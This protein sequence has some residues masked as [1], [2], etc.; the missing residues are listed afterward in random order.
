MH[1]QRPDSTDEGTIQ[2][3]LI[4]QFFSL[5]V[6]ALLMFSYFLLQVRGTGHVL[7]LVVR[8]MEARAWLW[9]QEA[10]RGLEAEG[11]LKLF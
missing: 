10:V 2:G 3:N 6:V 7:A 9:R 5:L 8:R 11:F 1:E 4:Q